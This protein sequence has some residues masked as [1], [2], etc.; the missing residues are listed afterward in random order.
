[1]FIFYS[2]EFIEVKWTGCSSSLTL[3]G[4]SCE[5]SWDRGS[6]ISTITSENMGVY[7]INT[8]TTWTSPWYEWASPSDWL[9]WAK[10]MYLQ[11]ANKGGVKGTWNTISGSTI[12]LNLFIKA[13]YEETDGDGSYAKPF[14]N[15]VKAISYAQ[16]KVANKGEA[17]VNICKKNNL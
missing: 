1:M 16:E 13:S 6:F 8:W 11:Y 5:K 3:N 12:A 9:S 10:G 2:S 7:D 15:I 14:G 17:T 4:Q